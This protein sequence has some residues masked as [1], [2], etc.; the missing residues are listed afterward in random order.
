MLLALAV[1]PSRSDAQSSSGDWLAT[2]AELEARLQSVARASAS[3]AYG[4]RL[5]ARVATEGTSIQRRLADGDFRVG[6]RIA[7][8]VEGSLPLSDTLTVLDGRRLVLPQLGEVSLAGVLRSELDSKLLDFVRLTVLDATVNARPLV[9]MAVFG[10]VTNPGYH[11][12]PM[13]TRLDELLA[14]AGGPT[15]EADPATLRVMRGESIVLDD[16]EVASAIV[17]GRA[18]GSLGLREGDQLVLRP[19]S[20]PWDRTM[21]I[22]L[23]TALFVPLVTILLVR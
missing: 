15:G 22:T 1:I 11:A 9:R 6:D 14:S 16:K 3:T 7:V 4:D 2:R 8:R 19:R 17:E 13:E 18:I 21:T 23:V 5:R 10:P 20:P 12:V